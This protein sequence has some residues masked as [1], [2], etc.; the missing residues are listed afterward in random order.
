MQ[1]L[2]SL[3]ESDHL[4]LS[5]IQIDENKTRTNYG[6]DSKE[7]ELIELITYPNYGFAKIKGQGTV[8]V[9][10]FEQFHSFTAG[11]AAVTIKKRAQES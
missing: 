3:P 4:R 1:K 2:N 11:F 7:K 6:F 9:T 8:V 5:R 10:C